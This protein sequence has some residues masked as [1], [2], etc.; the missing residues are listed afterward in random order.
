MNKVLSYL[1]VAIFFLY[2][3]HVRSQGATCSAANQICGT[4]PPFAANTTGGTAVGSISGGQGGVGCLGTTPNESWFFYEVAVAGAVS[5]SITNSNNVDVDG[6][7]FGPFTSITTACAGLTAGNIVAC[8][9]SASATVPFNYNAVPGIYMVLITNFSGSAT[10]IDLNFTAASNA[11]ID[12]IAESADYIICEGDSPQNMSATVLTPTALCPPATTTI[13][14]LT[15][16]PAATGSYTTSATNSINA[17]CNISGVPNGAIITNISY[18]IT[19]GALNGSF[20][21]ELD[22]NV[23]G[24]GTT[25]D[26][27][28][29]SLVGATGECTLAGLSAIGGWS[30]SSTNSPNGTYTFSFYESF[31]DA[32]TSQDFSVTQIQVVVTYQ[33][34]PSPSISWFNTQSGGTV[35]GTGSPFQPVGA[36]GSDV[37]NT[38]TAGVYDFWVGCANDGIRSQVQ[39]FIH[40]VPTI[41]STSLVCAGSTFTATINAPAISSSPPGCTWQYSFNNGATWGSSNTLTGIA[42]GSA[43]LTVLVRNSCR[44]QCVSAAQTIIIPPSLIPTFAA[45]GPYCAGAIIPPL[46]TISTNS[47]GITGTWSPAISNTT[48]ATYTFNPAAGQCATTTTLAITIN[49]RPTV[50]VNSPTVCAGT[51]ALVSATPGTT[52]TYSYAWTVPSGVTNPGN[53]PSFTS[54]VAGTYSVVITNTANGCTSLSAS[55]TITVN[56]IP[57]INPGAN[58]TVCLGTQVTLAATGA[59]TYSWNNSVVQGIAFTPPLGTT[60]YTVTGT[61]AGCVGTASVNVTVNPIPVVSAPDAT[62]CAGGSVI[63]TAVGGTTYSWAPG[64]QTTASITVSPLVNTTY[65]VTGTTLGCSSSDAVQVTVSGSAAIGAGLDVNICI[66]QSTTLTGTGGSIYNWDNALGVGNNFVVSP[67]TTT[68]YIVEGT[69]VNGC[70]GTDAMTVFVNPLPTVTVNSPTIC[71]G[72]TATITATPGTTASYSYVWTVPAGASAPGNVATFTT[73]VA[74]IYSVGITNTTTSCVSASA[75]GTVTV[76]PVPTATVNNPSVCAGTPASVTAS[77]GVAGSYSYVWTVPGGVT[78]PGNVASFTTTTA[79]TYSVVL[80]NTTTGCVSVLTSGVVSVSPLPTVT[81]NSPTV[82]AGT[83]ANV[84]ATPGAAGTY[85]YAWTVPAGATAP[86][87]VASFATTIAGTYSVIITDPVST[88]VSASVSG[89]VSVNPLPTVAVNNPIVCAGIPAIVTATPGAVGTYSY[90]W[91]VPAGAANPGNLAT[92]T[93]TVSGSY[94]VVITNT[95]T[96]CVSASASG[97]VTINPLPTSSVNSPTVCAGTPAN[98]TA[99]PGVAGTYNYVWT[100]PVGASNPGNA[101]GFTA[102]VSGIY[103]VILTDPATGCVSSPA[104]GTVTINPIPVISL[105]PTDPTTCN[106]TNGAVLVSGTGTGTVAWTGTASGSTPG[107]SLPYTISSLASGNYNV[108]FTNTATGC[109]STTVSTTLNNPGAPVI[110][111]MP[112]VVTCGTPIQILESSVTGTNLTANLGFFSSPNGVSQIADGTTFNSPTPTTTVYVYDV[113]GVCTAQISFTVTVNPIP[114]VTV[115]SPNVCAGTPATV[116]ATPGAA[117]SYSYA[118]TVPA[119][120]TNPGNVATFTTTTSGTYSVIITNTVTSCVSSSSSGT[121]TVNPNPSVTV[122]SPGVCAGNA[123]TVTATPGT[124][125]L[126]SYA[127]T[128]PVGA[129]APGNVATFNTTTAGTYSVII[130]N[131]TTTCV[132]TP[133]S[134]NV[135]INPLPT[136]TVNNPAVCEGV[137][138]TVTASPGVAGSYSFAWTV[139]V[140]AAT[141][142]NVATFTTTTAGTYSVVLTNTLTGC[143]SASASGTVTVSTNPTVSVNSPTVCAGAIAAVTATPGTAGTYSYAWTVPAG[144]T[145]PG[146]VANFNTTIAGTYSVVI[147]NTSTTCVSPSAS[148]NVTINPTPTVTVNSSTVCSGTLATVTASP[149]SAGVYDYAWTVPASATPPGNVA[150]FTTTTAGTYSVVI[151]NTTTGC[152]STSASGTVVVNPLPTATIAGTVTVCEN[153][154]QPTV[155]F[156]G[157]NGTAPYTFTYNLNNGANQTITSVGTTATISVPTSTAGIFNYNLVSVQDASSTACSQAQTG[158]A[159]ITVNSL[160]TANV[161]GTAQVCEGGASQTVT[162]TGS[163]GTA[164]YIFTY[165]INNGPAQTITSTGNSATITVSSSTPGVFN[166]N[167]MNVEDASAT[168]CAQNQTGIATITINALPVVFAGNNI[169]ICDGESVIL[170]GSGAATYSWNNGVVNGSPFVPGLG[171][172]TYTLTGTSS[173]GCVNTDQVDVIVNPIPDVSFIP[174]ATAGCTPFTTTLT[175]TT[176]DSQNCVWTISNGAV[177]TGCG[178]VPVTFLQ[179]GCYDVTL[180]TTATNGCTSTFT[181]NNL[182]C[183]ED[184]PI[185]AFAPDENEI[186]TFDTEVNFENESIG[187]SQYAW[188]FGVNDAISSEENPTYTYPMGEEGQYI[189]T[190]IATSPFGCQDTATSVIQ[191]YEELIFYVPNTFTPDNDN[192]NPTFQPV[193]TS[194]F[195]PQDF[196]LYIYNRWGELIFESRNAEVGWDGTYGSNGE[197]EMCQDGTYTWKIEFKVTRW[198]ERKVAIGHVNLIR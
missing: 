193:F 43:N 166:Y 138:A 12:C 55:G 103:S 4:T 30:G 51:A 196:V 159:T 70:T 53:V 107:V 148:G 82:C 152:F 46:P 59:T 95:V 185:A 16:T 112:N 21:Q 89:I 81:V 15:N 147:T 153:E 98:V 68:T 25:Y 195:D 160:P 158:V 154:P 80:T 3:Y 38:N 125:G 163:N 141:P 35:I 13:S 57:V 69:D 54:A 6:A 36:G 137:P 22:V 139:P 115:N 150:T 90:A 63:L 61:T 50:T 40:D 194:G 2:A 85:N 67:A 41:T 56:P 58:Q 114:T 45:V 186:S 97:V 9:Y 28:A 17:S 164:P 42:P 7:I 10:T 8:D 44:T 189:V 14:C 106:G 100:V 79:G 88:C 162:F 27:T 94:T 120:A 146:N 145:A 78:N 47:P 135:T 65:T 179:G 168:T 165:N 110:N 74:G 191:V 149:L 167:L 178:T 31:N 130:T 129:S 176:P 33:S 175:N 169:S 48:S 119:G 131:T 92:F 34:G 99:T 111:T 156:T 86:G 49:P 122:D 66:G 29:G 32:G 116:T 96:G 182:I 134:V 123:A 151:T 105:T 142:G 128:V 113:N 172:T 77:P 132:S 64:G 136:V 109:I 155:T 108:T 133:A 20:C 173:A 126:Y 197:I 157:A 187:A 192:Y 76:N 184:N 11:L 140:G 93:A 121:V 183:V 75:S 71:A 177:L 118:W 39:I 87:N 127:W 102:T 5:G 84:A 174:G 117:G 19:G 104:S 62:V 24:P 143:V 170:T 60:T 171:N 23:N 198:D 52:G 1:S 26:I 73:T 188:S 181:A 83:A 18:S 124:A 91:T 144:A 72:A 37:S 101:S 190:L 180:T 161:S